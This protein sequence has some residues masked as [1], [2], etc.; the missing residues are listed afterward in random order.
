MDLSKSSTFC[1]KT[2][3]LFLK[4]LAICFSCTA[5][6]DIMIWLLMYLPKT[7][8]LP[9]KCQTKKIFNSLM[10]LFFKRHLHKNLS[11]NLISLQTDILIL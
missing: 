3:L 7:H 1:C 10:Q 11:E 6:S 4:P 5:N 8:S 9:I 2:L